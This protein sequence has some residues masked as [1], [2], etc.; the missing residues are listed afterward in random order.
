[1]QKAAGVHLG[2]YQSRRIVKAHG[3]EL[4]VDSPPGEGNELAQRPSNALEIDPPSVRS[5]AP[6]HHLYYYV[7]L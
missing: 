6:P 5:Q 7:I 2:L 3:G 1:M 4:Y